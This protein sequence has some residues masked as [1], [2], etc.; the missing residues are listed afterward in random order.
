MKEGPFIDGGDCCDVEEP[1]GGVGAVGD[2]REHESGVV[3][4]VYIA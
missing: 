3:E 1:V 2:G 4:E